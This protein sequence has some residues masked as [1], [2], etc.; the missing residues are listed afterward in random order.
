MHVESLIKHTESRYH[1]HTATA[2]ALLQH[3]IQFLLPL[4][5]VLL[6]TVSSTTSSL[7]S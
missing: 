4:K 6:Y 3:G 1:L 7:T 5:I 2:T